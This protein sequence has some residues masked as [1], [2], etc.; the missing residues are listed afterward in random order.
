MMIGARIRSLALPVALTAG[1][2]ALVW[3]VAPYLDGSLPAPARSVLNITTV[4]EM[5]GPVIP[6]PAAAP[7]RL[8]PIE[9]FSATIERPIFVAS[10]RPT[11]PEEIVEATAV[12]LPFDLTLQGIL[13]ST[14]MRLA[15]LSDKSGKDVLRLA[16][17]AEYLGWMLTEI[18]PKAA[19][20]RR[21]NAERRLVLSY[22]GRTPEPVRAAAP[23]GPWRYPSPLRAVR[24][25]K[26]A[27]NLS[28]PSD[29]TSN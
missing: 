1:V 19:I 27:A 2:L 17:G 25:A 18:E 28:R 6:G 14:H 10:R 7:L 26:L 24:K 8:A 21:D 15:V 12:Q 13:F 29:A 5:P 9:S 3:F 20:F 22:D 4:P 11:K 23:A 16:E